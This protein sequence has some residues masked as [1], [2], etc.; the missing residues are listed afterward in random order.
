[1]SADFSFKLQATLGHARAGQV[2]TPHGVV[3]TPMFMPVGTVASV[4][5]LDAQDVQATGAEI[6]LANTYHLGIREQSL[7]SLEMSGG[8]HDFMHWQLPV[9]TDSGGFQVFSLGAQLPHNS[10]TIPAQVDDSGVLFRSHLDGSKQFFTAERSIELQRT[11]GADIIMAFDELQPDAFTETQARTSLNRT[12]SW[13]GRC[14]DHWNKHGRLSRYGKYQA[15]FG[16]AQGGLHK[17][18]RRE[19]VAFMA[20]HDFDGIAIGGETIGY[21]SKGTA[22]IMEW[23]RDLLP[24]DKPRYAMGLGR[25]LSDIALAANIGF[26][27]F[28]CVG[29]TRLARNGALLFGEIVFDGTTFRVDSPFPRGRLAIGREQYSKDLSVLDKNCDCHTCRAGYSRAYLRHLFRSKE[30]SYYR[31]ASIHNV[32]AMLRAVQTVRLIILKNGVGE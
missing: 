4:K 12:H 20:A 2:T 25:D 22:Q 8:I 16:I 24:N 6:I 32:R 31:L 13:A 19:S 14:L 30:L 27:M 28:D 26:D 1:M 29:P 5:S 11:I 7:Y 23:V 17:E 3:N 21:N 15:L 18:L 9:L 10:G